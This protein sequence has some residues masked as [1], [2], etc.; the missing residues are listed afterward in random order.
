MARKGTTRND[1]PAG[2][3][4]WK[5]KHHRF[6]FSPKDEA[7]L[8]TWIKQPGRDI[9]ELFIECLEDGWSIKINPLRGGNGFYVT[10]QDKNENAEFGDHSFG[11]T[12]PHVKGAIAVACY[13][14]RVLAERGDLFRDVAMTMTDVLDFMQ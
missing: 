1:T 12:W 13:S 4:S 14:I 9:K 6:Y 8:V 5:G 11:L 10:V 7:E 3:Q 2:N